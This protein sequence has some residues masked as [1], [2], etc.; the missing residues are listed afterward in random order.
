MALF[1]MMLLDLEKTSYVACQTDG[2]VKA[3]QTRSCSTLTTVE[4]AAMHALG[5][6]VEPLVPAIQQVDKS[7][8]ARQA[9]EYRFPLC[10]QA[11][12]SQHCAAADCK[13]LLFATQKD[14]HTVL[15]NAAA[16]GYMDVVGLL[17]NVGARSL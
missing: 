10:V 8:G 3:N 4:P 5:E 17:C 13:A 2:C 1:E 9:R 16:H 11:R 12:P 6:P 7:A 15:H 14:C